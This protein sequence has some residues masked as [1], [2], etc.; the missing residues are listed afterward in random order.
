MHDG[1]GCTAYQTWRPRRCIEYRCSL[2]IGLDAG[3]VTIEA[4]LRHIANARVI[5]VRV[6]NETGSV[7][8]GLLGAEFM[9]WLEA[10]TAGSAGKPLSSSAKL[11]AV[12]L[13][14]YFSKYFDVVKPLPKD[15]V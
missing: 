14:V 2:L 8:G 4:A 11:D 7:V 1:N 15:G 9:G 5:S 12:A 6:E 10:R 13:R 3:E